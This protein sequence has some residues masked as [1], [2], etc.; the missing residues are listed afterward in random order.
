MSELVWDKVGDRVYESGLDRGVLYLPEGGA[1][2]WNG[3]TEIIERFDKATSPIYYDGR[4]IHDLVALGD[5]SASLKAITYPD[6]FLEIEGL[7][8]DTNGLYYGDQVPKTFSLSYRTKIGNDVDGDTAGHKIHIIRNLTAIPSERSIATLNDV[9]SVAQFEWIITAVPEEIPGRRPTAHI[10]ID[11]RTLDPWLVEELEGMLYGTATT[12]PTLPSL[13]E[14]STFITEWARVKITDNGDGTWTAY[15]YRD[16]FIVFDENDPT[17][18]EIRQ[19]N[20][21]YLD[22]DTFE[23]SDTVEEIPES[24]FLTLNG[25]EYEIVNP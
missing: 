3:L 21:T 24:I 9:P 4:K 12:E 5:F 16:G 14:L 17:L 22:E 6:E 1:V 7:A 19:V 8:P 13:Q 18:F 2:A 11:T 15:A 23:I 25:N 20:A 10:I